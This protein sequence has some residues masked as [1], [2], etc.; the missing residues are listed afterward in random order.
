MAGC[1]RKVLRRPLRRPC[2]RARLRR[3]LDHPDARH[4]GLVAARQGPD[5]RLGLVEFV[6]Q[7]HARPRPAGCPPLRRRWRRTAS[8]SSKATSSATAR[9]ATSA[10]SASRSA[11]PTRIRGRHGGRPRRRRDLA[12][13][14]RRQLRHD[15]AQGLRRRPRPAPLLRVVGAAE[16]HHRQLPDG[17]VFRRHR[18][19]LHELADGHHPRDHHPDPDRRLRRLRAGLDA[20]SRPRAADRGDHRP[21]G[22][23]AADV[24][25]PAAEALQRRRRVLR[26][27]GQDLSR[28][29]ARA[30]RLRPALRDLSA[31]Q[32]HRRPA[33][34]ADGIG[35]HR[36]RQR[37]RDLRQDRAAAVVPGARLLRH[38]PVPVGVERSA[39]RHGVPR[40]RSATRSCSRPS[41]TRCSARA[42]A[43]G[44]SS[45]PRPSS[46]SSCR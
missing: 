2:R 27:A 24:A 12:G 15:V 5:H 23:A 25:D 9:P 31:A 40:H 28:H 19:L 20:L 39:G 43:T 7:L 34:R 33:A 17:A 13:Q 45:R 35:A 21:A 46:P 8:S 26:R 22:R 44:R 41:S 3:D 10:P 38:L 32:L 1:H 36:R 14:C 11:N 4:P 18:P 30:Y 6:L 16:I 29:L 37:L 42:A